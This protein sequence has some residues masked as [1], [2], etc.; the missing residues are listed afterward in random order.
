MQT[1][2]PHFSF[3]KK[4]T[5][6]LL[7]FHCGEIKLLGSVLS[8]NRA[9]KRKTG[10]LP[11]MSYPYTPGGVKGFPR[12][13]QRK[14]ETPCERKP[15]PASFRSSVPRSEAEALLEEPR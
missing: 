15:P 4:H 9:W 1:L 7:G 5:Q 13:L 6:P 12:N 2:G 11:R 3:V 10:V 14:S 8:L